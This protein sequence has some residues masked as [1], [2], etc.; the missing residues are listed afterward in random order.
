MSTSL[1][2]ATGAISALSQQA[3]TS[4]SVRTGRTIAR[5]EG[6]RTFS[7]GKACRSTARRGPG[8][9]PRPYLPVR[10]P[11]VSLSFYTRR[12]RLLAAALSALLCHALPALLDC[13]PCW[14]A[15]IRIRTDVHAYCTQTAMDHWLCSAT[16]TLGRTS[17]LTALHCTALHCTATALHFACMSSIALLRMCCIQR[18]LLCSALH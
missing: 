4:P 17:E 7:M 1:S 9:Q 14:T 6:I 12:S 15:T 5:L 3:W 11:A 2:L 10:D 16:N 13:L 18:P 8:T